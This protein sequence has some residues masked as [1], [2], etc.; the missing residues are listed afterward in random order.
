MR[1]KPS[2]ITAAAAHVSRVHRHHRA[3]PGGLFAVSLV[4]DG[5][6][7]VGVA[8]VGRPVARA[9]QDGWTAEVTRVAVNE[10][11]RNGCSM[12][13]GA[14]RRAAKALGFRRLIT[15]TLESESG[16]SLRASG[17]TREGVTSGG[18]WSTPSRTRTDK[19]PT[20]PKVRWSVTLEPS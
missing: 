10:G 18:S 6:E 9:L 5:G 14:V 4:D 8:I 17:W 12:L 7:T 3:P 2:T 1:L 20:C 16:A 13:Y 19:H 11:V 15:Y